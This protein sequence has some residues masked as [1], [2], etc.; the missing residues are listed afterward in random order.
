VGKESEMNISAVQPVTLDAWREAIEGHDA[1][2][3]TEFFADDAELQVVD[4]VHQPSKPL[5]Y[6]GKDAIARYWDDLCARDM[7]HAI[8]RAVTQGE[9]MAYSEA[10]Q[11]PNGQRVQCIA[12]LD[13]TDGKI[14][15]QFGVQAWDE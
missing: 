13:V 9:T 10:C 12:V 6:R 5:I 1:K 4:H 3:L 11:Y 7:T 14:V 8:D 2:T 15:R